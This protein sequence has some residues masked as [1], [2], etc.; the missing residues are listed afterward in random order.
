MTHV[1]YR[2]EQLYHG[3]IKH[4]NRKAVYTDQITENILSLVVTRQSGFFKETSLVVFVN[5]FIL[6]LQ[7]AL[8]YFSQI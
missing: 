7:H 3:N 2:E 1:S 5:S 6:Q 4:R 8:G